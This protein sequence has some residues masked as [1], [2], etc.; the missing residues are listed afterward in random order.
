M[1]MIY[2]VIILDGIISFVIKKMKYGA[3]SLYL[4]FDHV[5]GVCVN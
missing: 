2:Y 1:M 4:P 3:V 5:E